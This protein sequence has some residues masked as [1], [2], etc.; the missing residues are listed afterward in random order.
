MPTLFI[1]VPLVVKTIFFLKLPLE[2]VKQEWPLVE[3]TTPT[4]TCRAGTAQGLLKPAGG[5]WPVFRVVFERAC[6]KPEATPSSFPPG[7]E[8]LHPS[9]LSTAGLPTP[10]SAITQVRL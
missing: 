9:L 3:V 5:K 8:K 2:K 6:L 10:R 7:H 1:S 4:T